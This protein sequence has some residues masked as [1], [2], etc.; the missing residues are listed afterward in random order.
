MESEVMSLK[1]IS[2]A[3]STF[4]ITAASYASE[5]ENTNSIDKENVKEN[6]ITNKDTIDT[7]VDVISSFGVTTLSGFSSSSSD[8][9]EY[10]SEVPTLKGYNGSLLFLKPLSE[11]NITPVIGAGI[12]FIYAS[13]KNNYSNTQSLDLTL[14]DLSGLIQGGMKFNALNRL[15][16]FTVVNLGYSIVNYYK[17]SAVNLY[18]NDVTFHNTFFFGTSVIA[19]CELF[20]NI[21]IGAGYTYNNRFMEVKSEKADYH[22]MVSY[23]E[24]SFNAIIEFKI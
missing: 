7:D 24:N 4:L 3:L 21:S 8:A 12:N 22:K 17:K 18:D 1:K 11:S 14:G 23:N 19:S 16:L 13:G 15:E 20:Y 6:V 9:D 5:N 2:Y 10:G